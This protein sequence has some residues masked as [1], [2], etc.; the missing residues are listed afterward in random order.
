MGYNV[1]DLS[2]THS[3][4]DTNRQQDRLALQLHH[5]FLSKSISRLFRI[6]MVLNGHQEPQIL[7]NVLRHDRQ[8]LKYIHRRFIFIKQLIKFLYKQLFRNQ[9]TSGK[10]NSFS[11]GG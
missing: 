10:V 11:N 2:I 4:P 6:S 3:F 1:L 8:K 7:N 5:I 9:G